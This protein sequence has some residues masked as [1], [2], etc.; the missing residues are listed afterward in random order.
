MTSISAKSAPTPPKAMAPGSSRPSNPSPAPPLSRN[1]WLFSEDSFL[2]KSPSRKQVTL[3]QELQLCELIYAF[4]IKLGIELKLDGRTILAATVYLNRFYMRMPITTSK[5]YFTCAAVAI[6]CKLHDCY[7]EPDKIALKACEIRNPHKTVDQHSAHFWQWRDQLLY[8]EEIMLKMLNFELDVDLP[9]DFVEPLQADKD[10]AL[11]N[12]FYARLPDI[13][14]HTMA[15]VEM[16]SA[17][18]VLVAFDMKAIFATML[19]LAVKDAQDKFLP[20]QVVH[21]PPRYIEDRLDTAI[22]D[23]YHCYKYL[24]KLKSVCEDARYPSHKNIVAK[25]PQIHKERFLA[26]AHGKCVDNRNAERE[27]S[28]ENVEIQKSLKVE[29]EKIVK[30]AETDKIVKSVESECLAALQE[31]RDETLQNLPVSSDE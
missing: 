5:Y 6:S 19:V 18:P 26:I 3:P 30:S 14:K 8:R 15:K 22:I 13:F 29:S 10:D 2:S 25:I 7:R 1:L 11:R 23:C 24:L 9:Y 21:L 20:E 17:W 31:K 28:G 12:A 4:L 27:G 16:I